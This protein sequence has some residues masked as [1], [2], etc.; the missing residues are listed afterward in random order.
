MSRTDAHVK[1]EFAD[2]PEWD[3]RPNHGRRYW[4]DHFAAT[5]PRYDV[6]GR[7]EREALKRETEAER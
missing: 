1:A 4:D 6:R 5:D 3:F 7:R 2:Y